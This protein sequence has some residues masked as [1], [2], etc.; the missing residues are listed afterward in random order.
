MDRK[1]DIFLPS[2]KLKKLLA[3][4]DITQY[5]LPEY[6]IYKI[7]HNQHTGGWI[8]AKF[9]VKTKNAGGITSGVL[10]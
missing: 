9:H 7:G 2:V 5:M 8:P 4:E 6:V 1:P 10:R 3:Q